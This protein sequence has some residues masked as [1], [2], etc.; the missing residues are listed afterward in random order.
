[1]QQQKTIQEE[2]TK[3][4]LKRLQKIF[5]IILA[6][7]LPVT[8][9][10]LGAIAFMLP[11]EEAVVN[12]D[13]LRF[14]SI[15]SSRNYH[16]FDRT[17][18]NLTAIEMDDLIDHVVIKKSN[19]AQTKLS[20]AG[21]SDL[22]D[23]VQNDSK[24][25]IKN[26]SHNGRNWTRNIGWHEDTI[27]TLTIEVGTSVQ[28]LDIDGSVGTVKVDD[29]TLD[30]L[31]I[32]TGVSETI[33]QNITVKNKIKIK[34]GVGTTTLRKVN[35]NKLSINNGVGAVDIY[36][37]IADEVDIDNGVGA[38]DIYDSEIKNLEKNTGLGAV[39]IH[40]SS[41]STQRSHDD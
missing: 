31:D 7:T 8:L 35:T 20:Y 30:D 38:V 19:S 22:T 17:Y 1:M 36:D 33:I 34:N 6:I 13:N 5:G 37:L 9:I 41:V 25:A 12:F 18:D 39:D 23:K 27:G 28:S 2:G 40:N 26:E 24:L 3:M 10:G 16:T 15:T 32:E 11:T 29:L 21:V 14:E 4:V